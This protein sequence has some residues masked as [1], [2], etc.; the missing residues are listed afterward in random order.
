MDHL[1]PI[2]SIHQ[3][4]KVTN[5]KNKSI[6]IQILKNLHTNYNKNI[7]F[8]IKKFFSFLISIIMVRNT[9]LLVKNINLMKNAIIH[10]VNLKI[11]PF[12]TLL[13]S[14]KIQNYIVRKFNYANYV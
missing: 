10:F 6:N 3:L 7:K 14:F 13:L 12:I 4:K 2:L 9:L 1:I 8:L 5:K 11:N